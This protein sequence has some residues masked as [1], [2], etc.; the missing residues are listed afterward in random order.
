MDGFSL[1]TLI[2]VTCDFLRFHWLELLTILL[3]SRMTSKCWED[4]ADLKIFTY[5][6]L[7]SWNNLLRLSEAATG[8]ILLKH[9]FLNV[10]LLFLFCKFHRK[11][12]VL[13]SVFN[14]VA[15]LQACDFTKK[16]L[17]HKCFPVKFAKFLKHLLWRT[18]VNDYFWMM[19]KSVS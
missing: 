15:G 11:T 16:R 10:F 19:L 9:V 4:K 14:K 12:P 17:Q 6:K 5:S 3:T 1:F 7:F 18:S 8:C 2:L 13:E